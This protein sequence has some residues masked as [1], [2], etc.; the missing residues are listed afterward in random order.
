MEIIEY[1]NSHN[2]LFPHCY[3]PDPRSF[4]HDMRENLF[5]DISDNDTVSALIGF[6]SP[7]I[8]YHNQDSIQTTPIECVINFIKRYSSPTIREL[9][10]LNRCAIYDNDDI[11]MSIVE[12]CDRKTAD[13]YVSGIQ[14]VHYDSDFFDAYDEL[15]ADI[16][17]G[18]NAVSAY[19]LERVLYRMEKGINPSCVDY[20]YFEKHIDSPESIKSRFHLKDD[21]TESISR[22]MEI[23]SGLYT[24]KYGCTDFFNQQCLKRI[25]EIE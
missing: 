21:G 3:D 8:Y 22:M 18:L 19:H 15:S 10:V 14:S 25:A 11:E 16:S 2:I 7:L 6:P 23:L 17:A 4:S 12:C 24:E 9:L 13:T 20:D 1:A 5:W